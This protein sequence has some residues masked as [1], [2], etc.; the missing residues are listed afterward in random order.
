[1]NESNWFLNG[2]KVVDSHIVDFMITNGVWN[3]TTQSYT[4]R[5]DIMKKGFNDMMKNVEIYKKSHIALMGYLYQL[6]MSYPFKLVMTHYPHYSKEAK[7]I[8]F[9]F[10]EEILDISNRGDLSDA[11]QLTMDE[12]EFKTS[13]RPKDVIN[14]LDIISNISEYNI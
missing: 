6:C 4:I 1:M 8:A 3:E 5:G 9:D 12:E 2:I 11:I 10:L 14:V 7:C 13:V